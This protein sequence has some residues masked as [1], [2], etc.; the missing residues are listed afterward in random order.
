MSCA[1]PRLHTLSCALERA[2]IGQGHGTR[3]FLAC[4][5]ASPSVRRNAKTKRTARPSPCS[6]TGLVCPRAAGTGFCPGAARNHDVNFHE[7]PP[8]QASCPAGSHCVARS[9]QAMPAFPVRPQGGSPVRATAR[10]PASLASRSPGGC[11]AHHNAKARS[12]CGASRRVVLHR[13][14]TACSSSRRQG[15]ASPLRALDGATAGGTA[16][17]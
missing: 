5:R 14:C 13:T 10:A 12:A 6:T 1:P 15:C 9:P 7:P 8:A 16:G 17:R 4:G 2:R 11:A 3:S